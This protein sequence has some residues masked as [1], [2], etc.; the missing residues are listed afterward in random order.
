MFTSFEA[1]QNNILTTSNNQI[2]SLVGGKVASKV[3]K[4][5]A[6]LGGSIPFILP[7]ILPIKLIFDL[8]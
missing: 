7:D 2:L 4:A 8:T 6:S 5:Y 3:N 1:N